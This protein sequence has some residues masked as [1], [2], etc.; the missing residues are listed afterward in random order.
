MVRPS[1][2]AI[3]ARKSAAAFREKVVVL[4]G[5]DGV[6]AAAFDPVHNA[7]DQRCGLAGTGPGQ[8]QQRPSRMINNGALRGVQHWTYGQLLRP[9][10]QAVHRVSPGLDEISSYAG[11]GSELADRLAQ[12]ART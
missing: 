1:R 4:D 10:S 3:R 8:Y 2:A 12:T 7:L 5:I 11:I 6:R 9:P